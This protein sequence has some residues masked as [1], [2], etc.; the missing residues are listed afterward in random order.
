MTESPM[1]ITRS[2]SAGDGAGRSVIGLLARVAA[3]PGTACPEPEDATCV[4]P[5]T[6]GGIGDGREGGDDDGHRGD[7]AG[8]R[9]DPHPEPPRQL[10]QADRALDQVIAGRRDEQRDG[11]AEEVQGPGG[12]AGPRAVEVDDHRPVPQVDPVGDGADEVQRPPGQ[13]AGEPPRF[14]QPR[15]RDD[16]AGQRGTQQEAAF[17]HEVRGRPAGRAGAHPETRRGHGGDGPTQCRVR[18]A[19][20]PGWPREAARK[21]RV[22][23]AM[24]SNRRVSVP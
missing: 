10:G 11:D 23:P 5:A 24:R 20:A 16:Q 14:D 13:A 7:D 6:V 22:A 15:V 12:Q 4:V 2:G 3:G 1:I 8:E 19:C 17:E 21:A 18:R 9:G